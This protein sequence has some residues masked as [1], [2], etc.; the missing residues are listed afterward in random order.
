[1]PGVHTLTVPVMGGETAIHGTQLNVN[2][3]RSIKRDSN[4]DNWRTNRADPGWNEW[5]ITDHKSRIAYIQWRM[6]RGAF[7]AVHTLWRS[8]ECALFTNKSVHFKKN[9]CTWKQLRT[10][11]ICTFLFIRKI[12]LKW[13]GGGFWNCTFPENVLIGLKCVHWARC[14]WIQQAVF[15][16][17][18]CKLSWKCSACA[19]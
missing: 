14:L 2:F 1:M 8:R 16:L 9:N 4:P 12:T 7:A 15:E 6:R 3:I 19:V 17:Q 11:Q 5:K 18:K 13:V 10:V